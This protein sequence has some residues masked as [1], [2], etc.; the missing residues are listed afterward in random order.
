LVRSS[1]AAI[2]DVLEA[3]E[4]GADESRAGASLGQRFDDLPS[5]LFVASGDHHVGSGC[6]VR[7]SRRLA[8]AGG[9]ARR[10]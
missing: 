10:A 9:T 5:A 7:A 2:R 1:S 4:V 8:D 6:R 3:L